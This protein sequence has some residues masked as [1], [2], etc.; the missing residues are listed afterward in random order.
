M[1]ITTARFRHAALAFAAVFAGATAA[2]GQAA[3]TPVGLELA[4][5][6]DVSGSVSTTEF[7]LQRDGYVNAFNNPTLYTNFISALPGQSIAVSFTYW[8]SGTQQSQLGGTGNWFLINSVASSQA[9]AAAI[10]GFARP[11]SG[12][13]GPGS[14]IN[15][16][17]PQFAT[18]AFTANRW[19]I[20]VSGDGAQNTGASTSAARDAA[21]ASGVDAVNGLVILG[22]P[23]LEAWYNA[24]VRGGAG[25]FVEVAS[26]FASFEA[27]VER[28]IGREVTSTVPEPSTYVLMATGLLAIGAIARR[29]RSA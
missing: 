10:A 27:A 28:K 7:N 26:D 21:L 17:A 5:L 15:F 16:I 23:G 20:D 22:E 19:V 11:F 2:H 6:A 25:S 18:N 4:L 12:N 24:N 14:A 3:P 13:T 29:R 1:R 8:S 9:F